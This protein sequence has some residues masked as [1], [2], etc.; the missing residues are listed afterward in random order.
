MGLT[1][2]KLVRAQTDK[3]DTHSSCYLSYLSSLVSPFHILYY[4]KH[5]HTH[6]GA[7]HSPWHWQDTWWTRPRWFI[8]THFRAT[9]SQRRKLNKQAMLSVTRWPSSSSRSC[10]SSTIDCTT[11]ILDLNGNR[12]KKLLTIAFAGHVKVPQRVDCKKETND[13]LKKHLPS[14]KK[15][16]WYKC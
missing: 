11:D 8:I 6:E 13:F 10:L 7:A 14:K 1:K 4:H 9:P 3:L 5:T 15:S 2:H 16:M 12:K